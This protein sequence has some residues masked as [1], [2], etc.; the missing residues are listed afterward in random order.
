MQDAVKGVE[1]FR[2][3]N[4]PVIGHVLNMSS[5]V[6]S[7][8]GAVTQMKQASSFSEKTKTELLGDIPFDIGISDASDEGRPI[9]ISQPRSPQV[10][11]NRS[12]GDCGLWGS[13]GIRSNP[14]FRIAGSKIHGNR[15]LARKEA[16]KSV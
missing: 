15:L 16:V 11:R 13:L 8:C 2:K 12:A 4:V 7:S 14:L 10:S 9:V 6:C 5:Y 1:M 3:T